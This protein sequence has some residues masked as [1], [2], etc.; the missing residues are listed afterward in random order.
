[1]A[2]LDILY[3]YLVI[4]FQSCA[5]MNTCSLRELHNSGNFENSVDYIARIWAHIKKFQSF[6]H[7]CARIGARISEAAAAGNR[8]FYRGGQFRRPQFSFALHSLDYITEIRKNFKTH[9]YVKEADTNVI[10]FLETTTCCAVYYP[11]SSIIYFC[12]PTAACLDGTWI[13]IHSSLLPHAC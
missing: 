1:M 4:D 9:C 6:V 3:R 2:R 13:L 11:A 12:C 7:Y 10:V 8:C 5:Y